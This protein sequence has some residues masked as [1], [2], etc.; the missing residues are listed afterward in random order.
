MGS[1]GGRR[2]WKVTLVKRTFC[3]VSLSWGR[4]WETK[5]R[6]MKNRLVLIMVAVWAVL[7]FQSGSC[8]ARYFYPKRM[9]MGTDCF[10]SN[11]MTRELRSGRLN[12]YLSEMLRCMATVARPRFGK[13]SGGA[14]YAAEVNR[15][16]VESPLEVATPLHYE[17]I[18]PPMKAYEPM[19]DLRRLMIASRKMT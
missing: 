3:L 2:G 19:E 12:N 6:R 16:S 5:P 18:A 1:S 15:P 4:G 8:Q 13:R 7:A 10:S 9:D 11:G 14:Q 17:E